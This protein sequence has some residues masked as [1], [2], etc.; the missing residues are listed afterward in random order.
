MAKQSSVVLLLAKRKKTIEKTA[1]QAA[2]KMRIACMSEAERLRYEEAAANRA[3]I[4]EQKYRQLILDDANARDALRRDHEES[5][6]KQTGSDEAHKLAA[7]AMHSVC[8]FPESKLHQARSKDALLTHCEN[9]IKDTPTTPVNTNFTAD[10]ATCAVFYA[11]NGSVGVWDQGT[12]W[13]HPVYW[14]QYV[15]CL[16]HRFREML[17]SKVATNDIR[18]GNYNAVFLKNDKEAFKRPVLRASDGSIISWSDVAVRLTR[19]DAKV[20][21]VGGREETLYRFQSLKHATTELEYTLRAASN[22]YGP[23]VYAAF[24][25][26]APDPNK[27]MDEMYNIEGENHK[28][29]LYGS[30]YVM[31]RG[32][33]DLNMYMN[34]AIE[35]VE[36][37]QNEALRQIRCYD[38]GLQAALKVGKAVA[39]QCRDFT[40]N[41]DAK[42]GNYVM[43]STTPGVNNA[44]TMDVF[45]CSERIVCIDFDAMM[46]GTVENWSEN[47]TTS[48]KWAVAYVVN[49]LLLSAHVRGGYPVAFADGWAKAIRGTLIYMCRTTGK[50]PWLASARV[51]AGVVFADFFVVDGVSAR[52]RIES[53]VSNYFVSCS[54][55]GVQTRFLP[56]MTPNGP[57]LLTQLARFVLY[58]SV[59]HDRDLVLERALA[60]V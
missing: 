52:W 47:R 38:A 31:E 15:N 3:S 41:F 16:S 48:S 37:V 43:L 54:S 14:Q 33:R 53:M 23:R 42:P 19:P 6:R 13:N 39:E 59:S 21:Q 28:N 49:L 55:E 60:C 26:R 35:D 40:V 24:L 22:K 12:E 1:K 27:D 58:G 57:N 8:P 30:F 9:A 25:Y 34:K 2:R 4:Q 20:A 56:N 29:S 36:C 46:S 5:L 32:T 17:A 51:K 7:Y 18:H 44:H 11:S 45:E 50:T 10:P